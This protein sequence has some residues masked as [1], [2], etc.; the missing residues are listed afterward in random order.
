MTKRKIL[1]TIVNIFIGIFAL[2]IFFIILET[3]LNVHRSSTGKEESIPL[4][5]TTDK[6]YLY[7]MNPAHEKVNSFGLRDDEFTLEKPEGVFRILVLGDSLPYGRVVGMKKTFPNQLERIYLDK[8]KK[9]EVINAGVSGY[10]PY[11]ELYYY[12]EEGRKFKPDMIIVAF[13]MN[14]VANPRLHWGYTQEKIT[15]IPDEAIPSP[16]YDR[17]VILPLMQ[18]RQESWSR[19][20]DGAKSLAS[21]IVKNTS[22]YQFID[23]KLSVI[24]PDPTEKKFQERLPDSEKNL[25]THITAED[26]LSIE[27]LTRRD[28][29][30]W[31]WLRGMYNKIHLA[32]KIDGIPLVLAIFPLAYQLDEGYPYQPGEIFSEYCAEENMDCIDML[33]TFRQEGKEKIFMLDKERGYDIWHLTAEGHATTAHALYQHLSTAGHVR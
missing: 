5:I 3:A 14:D 22:A 20:M 23:E 9:V 17:E 12:L 10:S 11:N 31:I 7:Q 18:E 19:K 24:F 28:S 16:T 25:L 15:L 29:E 32:T 8:G 6:P 1:L 2:V 30:E 4:Y 21:A 27:V 26:N 13:C 33:S